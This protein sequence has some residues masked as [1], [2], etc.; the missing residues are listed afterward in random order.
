[1]DSTELYEHFR[2]Q[3]DDIARPFLW[4][5][6]EVWRYGGDAQRMFVRLTGGVADITSDAT[7][8]AITTGERTTALHP[9][10]LRIMSAYRVSDGA[11]V[12]IVNQTDLLGTMLTDY[13]FTVRE[14]QKPLPGP[15]AAM[16]LGMQDDT[17]VFP[18]IPTADDEIQ[19]SIYR[20]PLL[21]VDGDGQ[22][23]T[24]V[25]EEHHIR[26]VEWMKH[27]AYRKQDVETY[28]L[29]KSQEAE[30][31]FRAYCLDVK[32]ER[33]RKKHKTRVVQYGGI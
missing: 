1:M 18:V 15:V 27:L 28:D 2:S 3:I 21:I 20:T 29:K 17:G 16:V 12:R 10:I 7:R 25:A 9:S 6:A 13:G 5:D 32:A 33:E 23:L 31:V 30:A 24:D 26:L 4:S 11:D 14:L 22:A 8:A 19:M